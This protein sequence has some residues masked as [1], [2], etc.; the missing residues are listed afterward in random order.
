MV[1]LGVRRELLYGGV[2]VGGADTI[3]GHVTAGFS[4]TQPIAT[5]VCS[6]I[7]INPEHK[8]DILWYDGAIHYSDTD[9]K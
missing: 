4:D 7:Q 9:K 5:R 6:Y 2:L 3:E 8:V 1:D